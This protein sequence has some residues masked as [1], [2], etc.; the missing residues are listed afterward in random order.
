VRYVDA[1]YVMRVN[2]FSFFLNSL[3]IASTASYAQSDDEAELAKNLSNPVAALISVPLQFNYDGVLA[4]SAKA[5]DLPSI[6][7]LLFR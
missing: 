5:R 6:F 1:K 4:Y 2:V 7:S 3:L